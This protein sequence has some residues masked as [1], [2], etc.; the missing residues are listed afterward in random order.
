MSCLLRQQEHSGIQ[1]NV[2]K[3]NCKG[4]RQARKLLIKFLMELP[5]KATRRYQPPLLS[6]VFLEVLF[7]PFCLCLWPQY[8]LVQR[9]FALVCWFT[10]RLSKATICLSLRTVHSLLLDLFH[11]IK[12]C[13]LF[14]RGFRKVFL[15][16]FSLCYWMTF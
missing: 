9:S 7:H 13:S 14:W 11:F 2:Q 8:R 15:G 12:L 5:V 4:N 10:A 6:Q 1:I 3:V 16:C